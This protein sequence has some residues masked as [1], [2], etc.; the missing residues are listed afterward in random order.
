MAHVYVNYNNNL[1]TYLATMRHP[2]PTNT[3]HTATRKTISK[4]GAGG[5]NCAQTPQPGYQIKNVP[6]NEDATIRPW[7]MKEK[8]QPHNTTHITHKIRNTTN[9]CMLIQILSYL[10]L[11]I[12]SLCFC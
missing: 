6:K 12:F 3:L 10:Y 7:Y 4:K 1:T 8:S 2:D 5:N 9:W 11:Y